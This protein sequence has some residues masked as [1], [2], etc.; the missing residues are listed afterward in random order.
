MYDGSKI[1]PGL[2][3]FVGL[4]TSP[5]W[6]NA[7]TGMAAAPQLAAPTTATQCVEPAD[8]MRANHFNLLYQWRED[9]VRNDN[10]VYTASDGKT[11]DESLT[12]TC[13]SCHTDKAA[14]CDSC[15]TYADVS[16]NCWDCH[17][18]PGGASQ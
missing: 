4:I 17:V 9:V 15:H 10:R 12:N 1:I 11:Y 14:F 3:I 18:V 7:A 6:Y 5:F 2:I 16:P 8:W 13:L